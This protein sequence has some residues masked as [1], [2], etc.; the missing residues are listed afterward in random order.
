VINRTIENLY[1]ISLTRKRYYTC[2]KT[3]WVKGE[4]RWLDAKRKV[5]EPEYHED[6]EFRDEWDSIIEII[7]RKKPIQWAIL[8]RYEESELLWWVANFI[9]I[10]GI[11]D[12]HVEY[13]KM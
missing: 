7:Q 5:L 13:L 2:D 4:L 8:Y 6:N 12:I 10:K 9:L 3:V 11:K 1:D